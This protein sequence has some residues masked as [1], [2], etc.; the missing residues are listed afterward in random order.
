LA[1]ARHGGTLPSGG[2]GMEQVGWG[3][4]GPAK[5]EQEERGGASTQR[6]RGCR[7]GGG[8][9][10][11]GAWPGSVEQAGRAARE[12]WSRSAGV[13][14]EERGGAGAGKSSRTGAQEQYDVRS[15][16]LV[17]QDKIGILCGW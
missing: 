6:R 1:G 3:E 13:E 9:A 17:S 10:W 7:W 11:A 4:Q 5:D 8:R 14:Q 15:K 2:G 16:K 12:V